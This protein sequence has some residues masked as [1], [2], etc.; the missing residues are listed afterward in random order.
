VLGDRE[1]VFGHGHP[2]TITTGAS[3]SAAYRAAGRMPAALQL[4]EKC[5]ADSERVLGLD[6]PDTLARM[7]K[8]AHLYD[9]VG[10]I[11]DA[12]ELLRR[13]GLPHR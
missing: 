4:A 1:K 7:A 6:H 10:R 9:E 11:G 8:L 3:L 12:A 5:C 2:A 13:T